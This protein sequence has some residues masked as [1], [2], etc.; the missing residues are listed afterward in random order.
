[1]IHKSYEMPVIEQ[2]KML[3]FP[4]ASKLVCYSVDACEVVPKVMGNLCK[5]HALVQDRQAARS[6][7]CH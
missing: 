4:I 7:P 6:A 5:L 3:K 2:D 1:M